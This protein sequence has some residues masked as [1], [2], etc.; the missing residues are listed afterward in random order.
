MV[1]PLTF[2]PSSLG[3]PGRGMWHMPSWARPGSLG[4]SR[5]WPRGWPS[6]LGRSQGSSL[7]SA[8]LQRLDS[9]PL[10]RHSRVLH[11]LPCK[12]PEASDPGVIA[13]LQICGRRRAGRP[14]PATIGHL[15]T[16]GRH[17]VS[18]RF[19]SYKQTL[20]YRPHRLIRIP[21]AGPRR[22]EFSEQG[23]GLP[24]AGSLLRG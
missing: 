7:S 4:L 18:R 12:P 15:T 21:V 17:S 24:A 9:L 2:V 6:A 13:Q 8:N 22:R 10:I 14:R 20:C 16:V 19:D 23:Q 11:V 5:T 3:R 1:A